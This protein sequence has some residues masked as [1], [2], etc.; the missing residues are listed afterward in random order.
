[1]TGDVVSTLFLGAVIC[2][3]WCLA[4]RAIKWEGEEDENNQ[5]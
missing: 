3:A 1:M 5:D 4:D 2:L